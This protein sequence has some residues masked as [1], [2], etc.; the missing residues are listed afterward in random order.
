MDGEC[1]DPQIDSAPAGDGEL[2][3]RSGQIWEERLYSG[4]VPTG[5]C[6]ET[7]SPDSSLLMWL[8]FAAGEGEQV[9]NRGR[10]HPASTKSRRKPFG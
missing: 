1:K 9:M 8:E 2:H 5:Q 3:A 10:P 6:S 4:A 7:R